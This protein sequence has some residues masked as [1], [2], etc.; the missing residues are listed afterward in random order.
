MKNVR[1]LLLCLLL[2][3]SFA[4][5]GSA[6]SLDGWTGVGNYGTLGADGV[7]TLSPWGDAEYGYISTSGGVVG[8]DIAGIG[9]TNGSWIQSP[10][11]SANAGD[12]LRFFFNYVTS[13]GAGYADYAWARLLD[14]M[15]NEVALLFTARTTPGGDTVPGFDMPAPSVTLEPE[16]TPIIPGAP[17]WSPLGSYSGRCWST[18]CGYT[19]WIGASYEVA[20][21]GNYILQLGVMN[22]ADQIYDSGLAFDGATIAGTVIGDDPSPVP[23]PATLLLLGSGLAGLALYRRR[24]MNK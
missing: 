15:L 3:L 13:D 11:F 18:G 6:I 7:V 16:S 17:V 8:A 9:G 10:T 22:W 12:E 21:A 2:V 14:D 20:S 4:T 24:S 1:A 23:E 5:V 19:G